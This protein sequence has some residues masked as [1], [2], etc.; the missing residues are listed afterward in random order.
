ML[1]FPGN[2][3]SRL[4]HRIAP[5][6][7]RYGYWLGRH[8]RL[9]LL[10]I[11]WHTVPQQL[12]IN[13][14]FVF[15]QLKPLSHFKPLTNWFSHDLLMTPLCP[16]FLSQATWWYQGTS[17]RAW[18]MSPHRRRVVVSG[19]LGIAWSIMLSDELV[20]NQYCLV[21]D[22]I[23]DAWYAWDM[24]IVFLLVLKQMLCDGL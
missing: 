15:A 14:P 21:Y 8:H 7:L 1:L 17:L 3:L 4:R 16:Q 2:N 20:M 22:H 19:L 5:S 11:C 13:T 24:V 23:Y 18:L 6:L 9:S 10:T 12:I